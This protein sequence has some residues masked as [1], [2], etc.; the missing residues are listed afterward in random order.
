MP[1]IQIKSLPFEQDFDSK[2]AIID[3][4]GEFASALNIDI[5]HITVTWEFFQPDS[6]ALAGKTLSLQAPDSHPVLVNLLVPDFN[7]SDRVKKC[8]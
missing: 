3:I 1:I 2:K 8:W 5:K 7:S 6:Y 4:S